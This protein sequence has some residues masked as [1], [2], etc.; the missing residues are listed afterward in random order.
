MPEDF[1]V[2]LPYIFP[3]G[4][5]AVVVA[6]RPNGIKNRNPTVRR[7]PHGITIHMNNY[8]LFHGYSYSLMLGNRPLRKWSTCRSKGQALSDQLNGHPLLVFRSGG[9]E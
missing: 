5:W 8:T 2:F 7:K 3:Y 4:A 6:H 9:E 1:R